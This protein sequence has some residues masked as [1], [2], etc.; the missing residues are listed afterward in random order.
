MVIIIRM[1]SIIFSFI[2]V[3]HFGVTLDSR[4]IQDTA[5]LLYLLLVLHYA[6]SLFILSEFITA[7]LACGSYFEISVCVVVFVS[8]GVFHC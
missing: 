7:R 5:G 3:L 4:T 1:N 8:T 6:C 2:V